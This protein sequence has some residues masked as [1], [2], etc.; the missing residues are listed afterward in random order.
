MNWLRW[1][2]AVIRRMLWMP[3]IVASRLLSV[4][5]TLPARMAVRVRR[6]VGILLHLATETVVTVRTV[7]AVISLLFHGWRVTRAW[8]AHRRHLNKLQRATHDV[9][10]G[11]IL[12]TRVQ[13]L[14][15]GEDSE[16]A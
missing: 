15:E 16:P 10:R 1:C 8:R 7:W 9:M 14:T 6:L 5:R 4:R 3:Y 12:G 11:R 13:I 2:G